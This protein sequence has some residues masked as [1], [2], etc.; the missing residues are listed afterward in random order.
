MGLSHHCTHDCTDDRFVTGAVS[1]GS[2]SMEA[3]ATLAAAM[4]S[5]GAK[6]NTGEGHNAHTHT[7]TPIPLLSSTHTPSLF[8]SIPLLSF[9]HT[10]SFFL[11][12][13]LLSCTR[14]L[15]PDVCCLVCSFITHT[16]T[17]RKEK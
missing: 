8:L 1:Y 3:H 2:I 12:I 17:H 14:T 10:P 15:D 9:T 13:P 4:N 7:H 16:H 11:A 6:S 5:M